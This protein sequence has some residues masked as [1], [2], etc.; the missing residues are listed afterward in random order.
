M[1]VGYWLGVISKMKINLIKVFPFRL[2][3]YYLLLFLAFLSLF[4]SFYN[5]GISLNPSTFIQDL[6]FGLLNP[7]ESYSLRK[8]SV[9]FALNAKSSARLLNVF[10]ILFAFTQLFFLGYSIYFWKFLNALKKFIF[11]FYS[12]LYLSVG[13]SNGTNSPIFYFVIYCGTTLL[14]VKYLTNDPHVCRSLLLIVSLFILSLIFFSSSV[15]IRGGS[16]DYLLSTSSL[17]D[18]SLNRFYFDF[19]ILA[20]ILPGLT[21]FSYYLAQGYY[22]F[23]LSL[24]LE[25]IWTFGF[26]SSQFLQRQFL[27]ITGFDLS[28]IT[29]QSRISSLWHET[30]QWHSLYSQLAN[31]FGFIGVAFVMFFIGYFLARIWK[32]SLLTHSPYSIL[33]IPIF[34]ILIIFIPA[35]NQ[36]FGYIVGSSY[37]IIVSLISLVVGG[38]IIIR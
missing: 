37:I 2:K 6:V 21:W 28:N 15:T 5:S 18:I 22:G 31:D 27:S 36:I 23:S 30:A 32:F 4:L 38:K 19:P 33:L 1:I 17:G 9:D 13:V 29:L 7:A 16:Y 8:E 20:P 34:S 10:S 25:P 26:G 24:G 14:V 35:N 11:F 12:F 3:R